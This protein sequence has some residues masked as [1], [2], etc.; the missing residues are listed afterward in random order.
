MRSLLLGGICFAAFGASSAG[1]QTTPPTTNSETLEDA[2]GE[3]I[4]VKG[5]RPIR[6]S[7]EAALAIQKNSISLVSVI[8]ADSV[9]RLPD[10]NIAQAV[11]RLPGIA[12]QRDQGQ[13]RSVSVRGAPNN[14]T[15]LAFD[16]INV[17]SP[18]GRRARFD[19]IPSAIAAQII[20]RKAVTPDMTAETIAGN[21]NVV[22]RSAFDHP[23]QHVALRGGVGYVD[24]GGGA[25]YEGTG[26]IS[27]RFETG[28][29]EIGFVA[30]GSYYQRGMAT[31]NF[32]TDWETVARDQRPVGEGP[33]PRVWARET[34]N[35]LYRLTRA[36]YSASIKLEWRP[37]E[38][39]QIFG[40]SIFSAFTDNELRW[41][42]IYDFDDQENLVPNAATPCTSGALT[43][44]T[45]GYADVCAGNTPFLGTV[46]GIDINHNS[47]S[48]QF[49]QSVFINT[50]GGDHKFNNWTVGWRGNYTQSRDNRSAPAQLN[51]DSPAFGTA[52][53]NAINRPSVVY[54]LRDPQLARVEL[55]RTLRA[56]NGTLSRGD[57]VM[58]IED[59]PLSLT[60][61]RS[62]RAIDTT[63]AYTG[64]IDVSVDTS[65]LGDTKFSFGA[66][67]DN[68]TKGVNESLL[69][70]NP[71]TPSGA[72]TAFLAAGIPTGIAAIASNE[73]YRGQLPLGFNFRNFSQVAITDI[74]NRLI[75]FGAFVP[76]NQ[77][78][79]RVK[80]EV[81][82]GYVMGVSKFN[83]GNIVYGVRLESVRN[84]ADAFRAATSGGAPTV[85][86]STASDFFGVFPSVHLNWDITDEHKLRLSGNTGAARPDYP[87][88][89][90]NFT[91]NDANLTI[92]GGNPN[93]R[94]ER[95]KGIDLY[96]EYYP[97]A[98]GFVSIGVF[99]KAV[100]DV[101][102][103]S[104]TVFNSD[105]L[106]FGGVN[107]SQYQFNTTLNG[108]RGHIYGLEAAFQ[109]RLDSFLKNDSWI[110][111]FGI[112]TNAILN[113]TSATTPEGQRVQLP[114]ASDFV[115]NVGPYY[116]KYGLSLRA[117]YQYRSPWLDGL[118]STG[119]GGNF[120]WD[121]DEELDV[122]ARYSINK[123][124]E[125]YADFSNVLNGP[126]RRYV[127]ISART[128][129]R[130]TFGRRYTGGVRVTF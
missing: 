91:F 48:R 9:G 108:G 13:A 61:V 18:E 103:G 111:G 110:G 16:G 127:G 82:S 22:T 98:G 77:N 15:T 21:I 88:L 62:T 47:L 109:M 114:G 34:E 115:L 46:N 10:Q 101:L 37:S 74:A 83:W 27:N 59:F 94:P 29:G 68:R 63:N 64:R 78:F 90:P 117:S 17:I 3:D 130:E 80:E 105:I 89:R 104:S 40:T 8:S 71:N 26:V 95:T 121:R 106:N 129:E 44:N 25:E 116:E 36:N 99:Y 58:Q 20:I 31:D 66:Q 65:L 67:Y 12:V 92:N 107:R 51:Y 120:F 97:N 93:A 32:E 4:V 126:G 11:S 45:T 124:F 55:F 125:V 6:E 79:Y 49:E 81:L 102:F 28:I 113:R 76:A 52:G 14:W 87:V 96:W 75:P 39:H 84:T 60:R 118:G 73:P 35:K 119:V 122:S 38:G 5:S 19:S 128:T 1:A 100:S 53:A 86:V 85:P 54:D 23:G 57:R 123:N 70:I 72:T 56:A 2:A 33:F 43:P 7:E 69:D 50:I 41:N 24:L 112:Q 30:S 42:S